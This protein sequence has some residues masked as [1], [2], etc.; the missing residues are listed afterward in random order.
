M[1]SWP[2][3]AVNIASLIVNMAPARTTWV[4]LGAGLRR[5]QSTIDVMQIKHCDAVFISLF[6][7]F[8][9]ELNY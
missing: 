9:A 4:I 3:H 7:V 1:F 8:Y 2:D 5:V 6:G